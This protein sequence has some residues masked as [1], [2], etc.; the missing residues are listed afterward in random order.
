MPETSSP[1]S[2]D[3]VIRRIIDP[4]KAGFQDTCLTSLLDINSTRRVCVAASGV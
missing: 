4:G 2:L 1:F 3:S